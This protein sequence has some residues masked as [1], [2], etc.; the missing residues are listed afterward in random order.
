MESEKKVKTESIEAGKNIAIIAYIT[1]VGLIIAFV[2]N[3][4]KHNSF[5]S[6]HIRQSLGLM[7]CG[8]AVWIVG[9][10]PIIGWLFSILAFF[11]LLYLWIMGLMSAVNGKM[12]P[13]PFLGESFEEWFAGVK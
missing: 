3:N 5:A 9:M 8:I 13:I 10:I 1:I 11:V 4:D 7:V 2:M 12:K 6:Y